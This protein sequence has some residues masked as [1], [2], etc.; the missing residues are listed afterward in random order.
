M[1]ESSS[2]ERVRLDI[3]GPIATVTLDRPHKLNALYPEM[4]LRLVDVIE[5]IRRDNTVRV[6]V[7]RGEG[8]AF[9]A[10]DDL[11]PEDRFKYGPPDL[12]SRMRTGFP[13]AV[14][15]MLT[16]RKPVVGI[17]QGYAV[18][19]GLDLALACDFRLCDPETK[20]GAVYVTRGLGGGS[21]YL[22]PRY[23]G[24]GRATEML[25]LGRF[26]EMEEAER[27]GLVS[28]VVAKDKLEER[29]FELAHKLAKGPT[30]AYGAIK[31]A[32]NQGLGL[33]PVKGFEAQVLANV[34]LMF[35][36]DAR[37]G[38]RAFKEGKVPE[39]TAEWIDLQYD[40]LRPYE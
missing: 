10:G 4:I 5:Q 39:F 33:D 25:L 37:I 29:A 18:G 1:P 31:N 24:L 15:D 22:L 6:M 32:R 20:F 9:C 8:R 26:I 16:L 3:D 7:L 13:R 30:Q 11:A 23:V 35:H 36:K 38:P 40:P 12:Q 28:E 27:L 14:L 19:A 17:V 21:T 34:E 2:L